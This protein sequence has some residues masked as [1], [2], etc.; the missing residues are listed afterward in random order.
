MKRRDFIT[1]TTLAGAVLS[2]DAKSAFSSS[3][4]FRK[5]GKV[6][7]LGAG[8]AGLAAA[9]ALT[10]AGI[11]VTI[12]EAGKR[13]GG[14]VFSHKPEKADGQIIELGAEWVGASHERLIALCNE[15]GLTLEDNRFETDIILSGIH[16]KAGKW[17][18]GPTMENFWSN[19]VSIWEDMSEKEK[20][21]LDKIDWWR[22]LSEKGIDPSDLFKRD[23]IDSTDFGESIRHTSAYAAFA[24]YAESS[25]KN[26]MDFK[27][28]GGNSAL[29]DALVK[30]IGQDKIFLEH[31]AVH[32]NQL[33]KN[34]VKVTCQNGQSYEGDALICAIPTKSV[35][36]IDWNPGLPTEMKDAMLSLQYSRIG[37]FPIVFSERFWVRD[38]F[39]M[40]TDTPAHYF[41]HGTKNQKGPQGVLM[42]YA[43]GDKADVLNS[44]NEK[45]RNEII[46]EALRPA[47]GNVAGYIQQNLKYY[48]G[49][50]PAS[51]GAYAFY[52]KNQWFTVMPA[53]KKQ[54][55]R[56]LFAG[57]HL[58]D[59][60]GF[61]EGAINSGEEAAETLLSG[62]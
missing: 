53:L 26:E 49:N 12:L 25:E 55:I 10:R 41:Y 9:L 46:L 32:I 37:K 45:Q 48:W 19:K 3:S 52:G 50:D 20:Q 4:T 36:G 27:I 13:A 35:L 7:I 44:V 30:A 11:Q 57:E 21:K 29:T 40:V 24:E 60:Q 54:H 16:E 14:R 51:A 2:L 17:S 15:F 43:T 5:P 18:F 62:W 56:T 61:M 42:C 34:K 6:I 22:F 58:A 1:K 38:D 31:K 39:D 59:W 23:L 47:F 33:T 8:F 28:K